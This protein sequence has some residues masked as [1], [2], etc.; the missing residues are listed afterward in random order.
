MIENT[1]RQGLF[2]HP[3]TQY[4]LYVT[5]LG[6]MVFGIAYI[7]NVWD[8]FP[9][10]YWKLYATMLG[11]CMLITVLSLLFTVI[12]RY[13]SELAEAAKEKEVV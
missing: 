13:K 9:L 5:M 4:G 2:S 1:E 7:T 10:G 6:A 11:S 3:F 12:K 8:V